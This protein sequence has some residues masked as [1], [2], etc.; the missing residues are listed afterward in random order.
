MHAQG[1][2]QPRFPRAW[3]AALVVTAA[4]TGV[5]FGISP[6]LGIGLACLTVVVYGL[7][8]VWATRERRRRRAAGQTVDVSDLQRRT[9]KHAKWLTVLAVLSVLTSVGA[10][11]T[12]DGDIPVWVLA[13][14][15]VLI[16]VGVAMLWLLVLVTLPRRAKKQASGSQ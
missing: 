1:E 2:S 4:A 14:P 3:F 9:R 12:N 13:M 7:F 6:K 15:P 10:I 5:G 16:T 8:F 11:A